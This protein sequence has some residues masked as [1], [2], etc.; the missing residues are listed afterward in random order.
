MA[1][2]GPPRRLWRYAQALQGSVRHLAIPSPI[3]TTVPQVDLLIQKKPTPV[4]VRNIYCI[5]RNFAEHARELGNEVPKGE[6]VIFL[7]SS[8]ALRGLNDE[9]ALAFAG[10]R[11][12]HEIEMVALVGSDVPLNSL[13]RGREEKCLEAIGLG[14]DLTR[15]SVQTK[16]K[17]KGLPWTT[18]KSFA[19]SAIVSPMTQLDGSFD[20]SDVAFELIVEGR[21]RQAGHVNQMIFDVP[22]QLR[23]INTLVP[24][25]RGDLIFTGTPAGVGDLIQG[26][27]FKMCFTSGPTKWTPIGPKKITYSGVL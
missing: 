15:R 11:F 14:L 21:K 12:S 17:E 9:S 3:A 24:L 4:T 25:L 7:K 20:L 5:G 10:E 13:Q 18:A 26:D 2:V 22:A 8:A 6:P 27:S 23:F 16:L 19:G 1:L